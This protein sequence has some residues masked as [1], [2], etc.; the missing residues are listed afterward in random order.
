MNKT[1]WYHLLIVT[2][3]IFCLS[4]GSIA[5]YTVKPKVD[6]NG[7][8]SFDFHVTNKWF[9]DKLP[10]SL[11]S[12]Y[13]IRIPP[14]KFE[15]IMKNLNN[16]ELLIRDYLSQA[17]FDYNHRATKDILDLLVDMQ[18]ANDTT[19]RNVFYLNRP[20]TGFSINK[21]DFNYTLTPGYYIW[22]SA[23]HAICSFGYDKQ[24]ILF[25]VSIDKIEIINSFGSGGI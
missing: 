16:D 4:C 13:A 5:R 23:S 18:S 3:L 11:I 1:N 9:T 25:K 2:S 12:I 6:R 20:N 15:S 24:K 19:P 21:S 7:N 10:I 14:D 17:I 22:N 8:Q